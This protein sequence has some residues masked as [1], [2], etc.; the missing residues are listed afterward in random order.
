MQSQP[1]KSLVLLVSSLTFLVWLMLSLTHC[2]NTITTTLECYGGGPK[3]A[4]AAGIGTA[5][6]HEP[7]AKKS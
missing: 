6:E 5:T 4:I 2:T 3:R 1:E 7:V